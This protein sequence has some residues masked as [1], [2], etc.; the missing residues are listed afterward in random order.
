MKR[1]LLATMFVLASTALVYGQ[2]ADEGK[3]SNRVVVDRVELQPSAL[4]GYELRVFLSALSLNGQQLDLVATNI[5]LYVGAGEKKFPYALGSYGATQSDTAVVVLVQASL[6][7]TEAL[8]HIQD[9]LDHDLL[10]A[11]PD[12]T[13]VAVLTFGDAT[14][15]GR[16]QAIRSV[17]GKLMLSGDNSAGDPALSDSLDRALLLLRKA[18]TDP[19]GKPIRKMIVVIGDGRD[20]AADHD[21]ITRA[22]N[23]AAKDG[24]R[25]HT[26]AY[27]PNDIRRPMLALGEL[28]KKSLGTFRWVRVGGLDSWK[29]AFEQLRN[30]INSQYVITFFVDAGEEIAGRK[31]H[32]TSVR[33]N[34]ES[35]EMKIPEPACGPNACAS[36]YCYVDKCVAFKTDNGRGVFGWLLMIGGIAVGGLAVLLVIGFVITKVQESKG[37]APKAPKGQPAAPPPG[38]LPDGRPIPALMIASGPR[39]GERHMLFN[40]FLIGKQPGCTLII[41][42]GYTS[43][44]HAQI[45]MDAMGNCKI[46]DRGSTNGTYVNGV[47]VTESAL[48][49]GMT[50]RIGSTE[51][52]FL[53]E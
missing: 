26:I 17:R 13:Q 34:A 30:E 12:H 1:A 23:R 21:R 36:G 39:T 2:A 35:N 53:A 29:A 41:E 5:K 22:G 9:S 44:Q 28:S 27:S 14:A 50:F 24:V 46:Y 31:M 45:G 48:T 37:K 19:E 7:Y 18:K 3:T 8:P 49:H 38:F 15:S 33:S 11:L 47:R 10:D 51:L 20:M 4:T 6:D 25:I 40:G 52:R 42:D 32:I 43:S 16:L